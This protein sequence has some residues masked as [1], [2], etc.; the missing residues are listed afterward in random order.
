M[1]EELVFVLSKC[2]SLIFPPSHTDSHTL[3]SNMICSDSFTMSPESKQMNFPLLSKTVTGMFLHIFFLKQLQQRE[4]PPW[5]KRQGLV[6][7]GFFSGVVAACPRHLSGVRYL[8]I[9]GSQVTTASFSFLEAFC[10]CFE[11]L[12]LGFSTESLWKTA[13]QMAPCSPSL[14]SAQIPN[15]APN[16]ARQTCQSSNWA[17]II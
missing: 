13:E 14:M 15:V 11:L 6:S 4:K 3:I 7:V 16:S 2:N 8:W 5:Q 9:L 10:R 17:L 1:Y 12:E